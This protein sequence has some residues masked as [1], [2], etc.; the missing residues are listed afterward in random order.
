MSSGRSGTGDEHHAYIHRCRSSERIEFAK[1]GR[2][3][4]VG[5][6]ERVDRCPA[7]VVGFVVANVVEP[8]DREH[9]GEAVGFVR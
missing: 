7:A 5:G 4:R 1:V 8:G 9:P 3:R 2:G 6:D